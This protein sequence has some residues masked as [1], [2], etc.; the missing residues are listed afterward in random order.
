MV[1][2]SPSLLSVQDC[3]GYV[4]MQSHNDNPRLRS[5]WYLL[6]PFTIKIEKS[7]EAWDFEKN[8]VKDNHPHL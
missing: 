3:Y 7:F 6:S 5:I 8:N 4:T 1:S 2:R